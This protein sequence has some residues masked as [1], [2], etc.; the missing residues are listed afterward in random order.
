MTIMGASDIDEAVAYTTRALEGVADRDWD[1][2]AA[3]LEWSCHDTA[4]H[5]ASCF[6]GYAAQLTGPTDDSYVPFDITAAPGTGPAGLI[7]VLKATGGL[8][9][10]AVRTTPGDVRAWHPYGM[11]GP[12]GFAAMGVVEA[13][14]HTYD[15]TGALG[16]P[17]P[18]APAGLCARVLDS[19]FP[20]LPVVGDDPWHTLLWATGRADADGL[21]R[22]TAWR[23]YAELLR[24][25]RLL[26]C[27]VLP[28]AAADLHAGGSGNVV[29]APG[30]PP[31]GTRVAGGIVARAHEDGGYRR[32]WGTYAIVRAADRRAVGAI[33]FHAAPDADGHAEVGYD[34]VEG[35]RGHGYATEALRALADWALTRPEASALR[36]TTEPGNTASEAVLARAGF[37]RVRADGAGTVHELRRTG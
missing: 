36:A 32:G 10:S 26:L 23:W 28:D 18:P 33:G 13:L 37:T 14:L 31:E 2:P 30:G 21:P 27:E 25:E 11:A 20:H 4:V 7:H 29:W 1:A 5:I 22:Q 34:L 24:T 12:D 35:A 6:L 9:S 16:V 15:V 3:G 19:I 8:L 17:A